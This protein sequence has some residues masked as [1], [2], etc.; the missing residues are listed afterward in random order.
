[1][2]SG[3]RL[4]HNVRYF[5]IA[6]PGEQAT[7]NALTKEAAAGLLQYIAT[8]E[9]VQLNYDENYERISATAA[10][11]QKID[12]F[13]DEF[14][15]LKADEIFTKYKHFNSAANATRFLTH[16][17]NYYMGIDASGQ[18]QEDS[19]AT[20]HQ[21]ARIEQFLTTLPDMKNSAEYEDYLK[22][23]TFDNA[24]ELL[25]H[26]A[27]EA[28]SSG[29]ADAETAQILL[30]YI[31]TRPGV[32]KDGNHGLFSSQPNIDLQEA[33]A[34]FKEVKGNIWTHVIS[35]WREDAD[36]LGYNNQQ[37]WKDTV[38][39]Q[40]DTIAKEMNIPLKDL[41][42]Y[43]AMHDTKHHPHIHLFVYSDN[44]NQGF[45]Q[46]EGIRNIK[47]GFAHEI[48]KAEF[49]HIYEEKAE[50]IQ[51]LKEQ[52]SDLLQKLAQADPSELTENLSQLK[53][54]LSRTPGRHLYKFLS[55]DAKSQVNA[56]IDKIEEIPEIKQLHELYLQQRY[57]ME[58]IYQTEN[59]PKKLSDYKSGDD[60]YFFKN[61]VIRCAEEPIEYSS[62]EQQPTITSEPES[63]S[64]A[65]LNHF[66]EA[67]PTEAFNFSSSDN[68]HGEST[69]PA[70]LISDPKITSTNIFSFSKPDESPTEFRPKQETAA[71]SDPT[72]DEI[73]FLN[74]LY[75]RAVKGDHQA[76]FKLANEFFYNGQSRTL[77]QDIEKEDLVG[78]AQM[79][80]GLAAAGGHGEASYMI[81]KMYL[82]GTVDSE[83]NLE[84]AE[85]YL[86]DSIFQL[87]YGLENPRNAYVKKPRAEYLLGRI[88][89]Q[90]SETVN[91]DFKIAYEFFLEAAVDNHVHA[92]YYLG[93]MYE[94]GEGVDQDYTEA[95]SFYDKAVAKNDGYAAYAL[96]R[97]YQ[98]GKGS[99][100][101]LDKAANLFMI[102]AK[103]DNPF[104]Q[105]ALADII[106]KG[107]A[108]M[109][110]DPEGANIIYEKALRYWQNEVQLVA[111]EEISYR[112]GRMYE[113]GFG[114]EADPQKAFEYYKASADGGNLYAQLKVAR[115][116]EATDLHVSCYYYSHALPQ[117][118]K[119]YQQTNDPQTA[120]QIARMHENGLG[121]QQDEQK[122]FMYYKAS[123]DSGNLY[124]Q[125]KVARAYEATDLHISSYY[126]SLALPQLEKGYQQEN[127]PQTAYQIAKMYENGLG[128]Q[129][130]E[131]KAY[132][133]YRQ[134]ADGG[135]LYA[136]LKT[137]RHLQ[138]SE[139]EAAHHYYKLALP[140][141]LTEYQKSSDVW[142]A[143]QIGRI[144]E[145]GLGTEGNEEQAYSYYRQS[146][147]GGNLYAQLKTAK[148]LEQSE[149]EAAHHYY[150]LALPQ[151]E[152]EYLE[153]HAPWVAYQLGHMYEA[154][155]GVSVNEQYSQ[156][157]FSSALKG[158][159]EA[160]S[161]HPD[162]DTEYRIGCMY[163]FGKG[164][165]ANQATA[166]SWFN[167]A[168]KN[169]SQEA[170][171]QLE[172]IEAWEHM[173][174][175][176]MTQS[177]LMNIAISLKQS[178]EQQQQNKMLL[179][180]GT[181]S[182]AKAQTRRLK[183]EMG[184]K[185]E[186]GL[187]L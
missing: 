88:F 85:Q 9:T 52:S 166:I 47:S 98:D 64:P 118:E 145:N 19:P 79:F 18:Y 39:T 161:A 23:P 37:P 70:G 160:E 65:G 131:E 185:E 125:L 86:H 54:T 110:P 99:E 129:Q 184:I 171:V 7:K 150:A 29:V 111:N 56:I 46:K 179:T 34:S 153:N 5:H 114:T 63:L 147:D 181:D 133:Y 57:N 100:I 107:T 68:S 58:R 120:F 178:S 112:I 135:N 132:S 6:K 51:Q 187:S 144:Y 67:V 38:F 116:F 20:P 66:E 11:A 83:K 55:A 73:K 127:D 176:K 142:I 28:L 82:Y 41:K 2:S 186:Q 36:M 40:I 50:V 174:N 10:Q 115:I 108:H 4:I 27:E 138:Q 21:Q 8:R 165:E 159:L 106:R 123:A 80:Y 121:T 137:A 152:K 140:Q 33:M 155:K 154:G 102:A 96:G 113:N 77:L 170:S 12:E 24:S 97:M 48:F 164:T 148:Y 42:W 15:Q 172:K 22:S 173:R 163:L 26:A 74:D 30:R 130:N 169:G 141:L 143:Y 84:L 59:V 76:Q 124:A 1:M 91:Q 71:K 32:V 3:A 168:V 89:Y 43:A 44:P 105:Y 16:A 87:E 62:Q 90:G 157:Y 31:A 60:L 53:I 93:R 182:K 14:P 146:A 101:D 81:A 75:K 128:T 49:E 13:I 156:N 72:A 103:Q 126:Y 104:A 139:P 95:I 175:M 167:T 158:Y 149:P 45:L 136:Q 61:L 180:R 183:E 17:A 162:A 117:L 134:S 109:N 69:P 119:E 25:T 35:L 92:N 78:S 122:A 151:L 177:L 94:R